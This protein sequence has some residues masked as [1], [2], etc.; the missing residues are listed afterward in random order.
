MTK[1][2]LK[3]SLLFGLAVPFIVFLVS[4]MAFYLGNHTE[5]SVALTDVFSF[6]MAISVGGAGI[7]VAL[8]LAISRWRLLH[9]VFSG[10][11][12]GLALSAWVQ[13]QL[14]AWNFG[15]LDGR[16]IDWSEWGIHA[17]AE[18]VAW[19]CIVSAVVAL[20][21]RS[22]NALFSV[23]QGV[24]LLGALT[25][26]S[27]WF[28]S[29]YKTKKSIDLAENRVFSFHKQ[30]NTILI[31]LD[32]FQS[33]VFQEIAA[34]WPEEVEFL[35]GFVF[36][37]N[38]LGGYPTTL[39]AVPLIITGKFYKN[40][41]PVREWITSNNT[42]RNLADYYAEQNYGVSQA[43]MPVDTLDGVNAPKSSMAELGDEK[44]AG[45]SKLKLLVLDGG[46]FRVLPTKFKPGFY[47][48]GNWY[49]AR[50]ANDAKTPPGAHGT[51]WRFLRE[52]ENNAKIESDREG[53][54]KYYHYI[55]AHWPLQV[56][57]NFEYE[58][59]M[60]GTRE[61]Y[62]R[63]SRGVLTVLRKKLK[64]IKRLG[65]Y[66][67]AQI[68]VVGDHGSH[69]FLPIDIQGLDTM[70]GEDI[71]ENI[72]ASSRPLFLYK[73]SMSIAPLTHSDD[74]VHL[75]DVVCILSKEDAAFEC[76]EYRSHPEG[77]ARKR[78]FLYYHWS[79]E[80][81][82]GSKDYMPPMTEY[83]VE[84]DVRDMRAWSNTYVEYAEGFK[85]ALPLPRVATYSLGDSISFTQIGNSKDFSKQGWSVPE[86]THRWTHASQSRL[87][88]N[89]KAAGSK[90]LK[91]RLHA[92][93]FPAKG[94]APQHVD[95]LVNGKKV[96]AWQLLKQAWYEASIPVE[97]VG[98]G[99]LN[100]IFA[101]SEPTAPCNVSDSK[102]CRRLGI[103]AKEMVIVGQGAE[104]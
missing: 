3:F 54:F 66:D 83:V 12:V 65:I 2:D 42:N 87:V 51:D 68:V 78:V 96:A 28:S 59:G 79:K 60:P 11:L 67:A 8:L 55:G 43:S 95:V 57:E 85:R 29:D 69:S 101:I 10:A 74:P 31:V 82:D 53:E 45:I 19:L 7:F 103:A 23:G 90:P 39:A 44:W 24:L 73:P 89:V 77:G 14:F 81:H 26:I 46:L 99:L 36:Y 17:D 25:L 71:G 94:V 104:R 1:I 92:S 58:K 84:G 76:K 97:V 49:F 100:I 75:A 37:P 15:P 102:D 70:E 48:E 47:E 61:S 27:S 30:N 35:R 50:L 80:Y 56:N 91:L 63:Q 88:L 6:L 72:L 52:L 40:E 20:A 86:A 38:A 13:S 5:Y 4:P 33:D 16:G 22:K 64:V 98:N 93:G 32:T 21:C 62:V 34:R 18:L 9:G 41:I